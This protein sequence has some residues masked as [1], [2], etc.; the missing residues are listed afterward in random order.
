MTDLLRK[1]PL[2]PAVIS[3]AWNLAYGLLLMVMGMSIRS[4]WYIALAGFFLTLGIGRL[5]AVSQKENSSTRM[6]VLEGLMVFLAIV[7]CG[8]TYLTIDEEI[9]PVR[10]KILVIAQAAFVFGM[11]SF[12]VYHVVRSRRHMELRNIMIR[13]LSFAAALG[14]MLS[15]Q[16]TMLGTFGQAGAEFNIRMEAGSGAAAAVILL[17]LALGLVIISNRKDV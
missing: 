10:N 3:T 1:H 9:N 11:V 14:S 12:A 2:L 16:R 6:R 5:T 8:I 17:L 4:Y 15:L 13:N 7:I